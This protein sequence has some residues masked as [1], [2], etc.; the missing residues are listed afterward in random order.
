VILS[1]SQN[2]Q[3]FYACGKY[4]FT[5]INSKVI[6]PQPQGYR[7]FS[8]TANVISTKQRAIYLMLYK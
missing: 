7:F 3:K 8:K 6:L 1:Y 4:V 2:L 5:I